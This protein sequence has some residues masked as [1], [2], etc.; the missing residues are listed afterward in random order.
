MTD[1]WLTFYKLSAH[2]VCFEKHV[3]TLNIGY[4]C[5]SHTEIH[6]E[7]HLLLHCGA[8]LKVC[9]VFIGF[10]NAFISF[11]EAGFTGLEPEQ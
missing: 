6:P 7:T 9:F 4:V 3:L 11:V 8:Y 10:Y 2:L 1:Q 5:K